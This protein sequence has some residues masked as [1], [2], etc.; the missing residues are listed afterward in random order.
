MKLCSLVDRYGY[1]GGT[2]SWDVTLC[3]WVDRHRHSGG[4][5]LSFHSR[6]MKSIK[7]SAK[8]T[9]LR[10]IYFTCAVNFGFRFVLFHIQEFNSLHIF[11]RDMLFEIG[12]RILKTGQVFLYHVIALNWRLIVKWTLRKKLLFLLSCMFLVAY[13]RKK[14][15]IET[16][17]SECCFSALWLWVTVHA[18]RLQKVLRRRRMSFL[19]CN[20]LLCFLAIKVKC[21]ATK[22]TKKLGPD[23]DGSH[24]SSL[25]LS[26]QLWWNAWFFFCCCCEKQVTFSTKTI[27]SAVISYAKRHR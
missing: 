3:S 10:P 6:R 5:Y 23:W 19:S 1:S 16:H 14:C 4:T 11:R 7:L 21:R 22:Q 25:C 20:F 13:W 12:T 15:S 9:Y 24:T 27:R 26:V 18:S 8:V 2:V 17:E